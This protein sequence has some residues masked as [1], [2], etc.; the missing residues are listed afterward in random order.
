MFF[1]KKTGLTKKNDGFG[2]VY[3]FRVTLD[4]GSIIHKVGMTNSDRATDRMFEVLRSFFHSYRYSPKC[5]LR[6]DKKVLVPRLVEKHLHGL[7]DDLKYTFSK[8]FDG[9][10]EF[11]QDLDEES[12][13]EYLNDFSYNELLKTTQMKECDLVA[14]RKALDTEKPKKPESEDKLPF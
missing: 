1:S 11:F 13:I 3:L 9:S 10:T 7:L 8:K 6:K 2:R 12:F 14:I 4:D 5:E